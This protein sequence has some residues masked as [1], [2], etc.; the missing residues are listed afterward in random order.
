MPF[1]LW[2]CI[3]LIYRWSIFLF[4]INDVSWPC[5]TQTKVS[6]SVLSL[7]LKALDVPPTPFMLL[8]LLQEHIQLKHSGPRRKRETLGASLDPI[9]NL[10]PSLAKLSLYHPNASQL[11]GA[12]ARTNYLSHW[13]LEWLLMQHYC[14]DSRVIV[15]IA[16]WYKTFFGYTLRVCL[17]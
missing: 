3:S 17:F 7:H 13:D 15:V 11:T 5:G 8:P 14:G 1:A 10:Q 16:E 6:K 9:F 4:S 2:C 12:W